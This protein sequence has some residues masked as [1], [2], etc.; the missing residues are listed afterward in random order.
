[1]P[2]AAAFLRGEPHALGRPRAR[3]IF[4][5]GGGR[6]FVQIYAA[7]EDEE[8]TESAARV[9]RRVPG[10][11]PIA[12]PVEVRVRFVMPTRQGDLRKRSL[13]PA[14]WD[15]TR[16]DLDNLVKLLLDAAT[17]AGWWKDDAIV[18]RLIAEK[19]RA[20]EG[21]D[22]GTHLVVEALAPLTAAP[23]QGTLLPS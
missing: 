7:P 8:A 18:V 12:D 9:L 14:K 23:A 21:E 13:V 11:F 17:A 22:T 16:P 4:P 3:A 6:A 19:V 20:A 1:M 15:P 5:K 2:L 10:P